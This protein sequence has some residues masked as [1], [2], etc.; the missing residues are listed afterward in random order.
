MTHLI[1][2][3]GKCCSCMDNLKEYAKEIEEV[4]FFL[5]CFFFLTNFLPLSGI[6][7]MVK[8]RNWVCSHDLVFYLSVIQ[9]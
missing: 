1:S 5:F 7:A 6:N 3:I 8:F 2:C 4:R 9:P